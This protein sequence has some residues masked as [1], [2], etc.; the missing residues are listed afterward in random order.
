MKK[1]LV[2]GGTQF[3]GRYLVEQLNEIDEYELTLFNRQRTKPELFPELNRIKGDRET[4]DINLLLGEYWDV[5]IDLSC[6]YP[7]SLTNIL[8]VL[9][10]KFN[11]Y[12]LIST[13]SV[14]D[15]ENNLEILKTEEAAVKACSSEQRIDRTDHSYGNRKA[16]CERILL[17][18]AVNSVLLRPS[19]VYGPYDHTDRFY[20]WLYQVK[21]SNKLLLPDNGERCFS[22]TYVADL[23]ETILQSVKE[24]VNQKLYNVT[25]IP[26]A[27]IAEIVE[28]A[29]ELLD[30]NQETINASPSFL[31]QYKISQWGDMPL[32]IDGDFF[33]YTNQYLKAE[34]GAE[35]TSLKNGIQNTIDYY[36]SL[37][38]PKP[39]YGMT[40]EIRSGLIDKL[41]LSEEN[42]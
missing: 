24:S 40:E 6:Y 37:N 31:H 17:A 10:G 9:E 36:E 39:K 7:D 35:P 28:C 26:Q 8:A 18:S 19:I 16:E 5:I 30:K 32:W 22:L 41:A 1:I 25:T 12:I 34:L 13:C 33:T 4:D 42:N 15:N 23:I 14:Y 3:I 27:S 11:Q 29:Q 2:L 21:H 20:Y 38:W